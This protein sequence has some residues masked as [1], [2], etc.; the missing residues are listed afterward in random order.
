MTRQS[1]WGCYWYRRATHACACSERSRTC[2]R[3]HW[4]IYWTDPKEMRS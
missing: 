4:C 1:C 3:S 2:P